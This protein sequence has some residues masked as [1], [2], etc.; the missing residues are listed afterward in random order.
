M[1]LYGFKM[2]ESKY[3]KERVKSHLSL[4]LFIFVVITTFSDI[5]SEYFR[6][7]IDQV[8]TKINKIVITDIKERMVSLKGEDILIKPT[9]EAIKNLE[10]QKII[11]SMNS[12]GLFMVKS[13]TSI[14]I[15]IMT[16]LT[17]FNIDVSFVYAIAIPGLM[18]IG[19][20]LF[21]ALI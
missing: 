20:C 19:F 14:Y 10:N 8:N 1:L 18:M 5:R 2:I 3:M 17:F 15:C 21:Y 6:S 12:Q 16:L 7:E 9:E 11:L 13:V 4:W